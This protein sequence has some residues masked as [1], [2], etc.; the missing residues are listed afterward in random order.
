MV[1]HKNVQ[2][3]WCGE[4]LSVPQRRGRKRLGSKH[5]TGNTDGGCAKQGGAVNFQFDATSDGRPIKIGSVVDC[6]PVKASATWSTRA[7]TAEAL[8]DQLDRPACGG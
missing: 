8:I 5:H 7:I 3:L 2:R 6:T 4:G 1:N